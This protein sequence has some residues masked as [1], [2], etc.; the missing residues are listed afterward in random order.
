[1]LPSK[2]GRWRMA[3]RERSLSAGLAMDWGRDRQ[4]QASR[5]IGF[6]LRDDPEKKE[7][8]VYFLGARWQIE[9]V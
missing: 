7:I 4:G 1:M 5:E 2:T 3:R 6:H 8:R 9:I